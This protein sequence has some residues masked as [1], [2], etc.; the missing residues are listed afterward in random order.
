MHRVA[1]VILVS[2]LSATFVG[3]E[4]A[5]VG[6]GGE[7]PPD[8]TPAPGEV[9]SICIPVVDPGEP[10]L[11]DNP[12]TPVSRE[13]PCKYF[14]ANPQPPAGA[15]TWGGRSPDDGDIYTRDCEEGWGAYGFSL[16][17]IPND[18]ST[19]PNPAVLSQRALDQMLLTVPDIHVAPA[20]PAQTY[21]GLETWLWMPSGQ[22]APLTK[23]VTAG[24]TTVTV[25]AEPLRVRWDMG[26]GS[27]VCYG[28]GRAW[29]VGQMPADASSSC[30]FTYEQ[31]SAFQPDG[32]FGVS[33]TITFDARWTCS[34]TCLAPAGSLGEVEGLPGTSAIQVGERQSVNITPRGP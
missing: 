6:A 10:A 14:L 17:F 7:C 30:Q 2:L 25:T 15:P 32:K 13:D 19:P 1:R 22:W 34:G 11:S 27:T 5:A 23:S 3:V 29:I 28:A 16:V 31:V 20:P 4:S 12:V 33:A 26:T 18:E 21:V 9:G 8:S 24:S